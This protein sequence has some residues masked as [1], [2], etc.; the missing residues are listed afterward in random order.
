MALGKL[1]A[2]GTVAI[3]SGNEVKYPLFESAAGAEAVGQFST[4]REV[5]YAAPSG[6]LGCRSLNRGARRFLYFPN[7]A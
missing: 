2:A 5:P 3:N 4:T 1:I 7:A 6:K